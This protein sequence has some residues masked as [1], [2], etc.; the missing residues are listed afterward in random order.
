MSSQERK[1]FCHT[2]VTGRLGMSGVSTTHKHPPTPPSKYHPVSSIIICHTLFGQLS[3]SSLSGCKL[4]I[5][6]VAIR[7]YPFFS[8]VYVRAGDRTGTN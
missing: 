4:S 6:V 2:T 7:I 3:S 8:V 1:N 5:R